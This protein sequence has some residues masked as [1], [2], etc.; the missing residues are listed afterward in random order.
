MLQ[1]LRCRAVRR[2]EKDSARP[3]LIQPIRCF[4][5]VSGGRNTLLWIGT[6]IKIDAVHHLDNQ[7]QNPLRGIPLIRACAPLVRQVTP[8]RSRAHLA[9]LL[10]LHHISEC[11]QH[12]KPGSTDL[13]VQ[14][15]HKRTAWWSRRIHIRM[16]AETNLAIQPNPAQDKEKHAKPCIN[17]FI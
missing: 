7:I 6:R 2:V 8:R 3:R 17:K 5:V 4:G 15:R 11:L 9:L 13:I 14:N 10:A 12:H 1:P 16:L